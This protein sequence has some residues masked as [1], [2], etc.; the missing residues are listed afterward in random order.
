MDLR[1]YLRNPLALSFFPE[2]DECR[3]ILPMVSKD[4]SEREELKLIL[5]L[6]SLSTAAAEEPL[7]DIV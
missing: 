2:L 7:E 4:V 5:L 1:E 6:P 3:D